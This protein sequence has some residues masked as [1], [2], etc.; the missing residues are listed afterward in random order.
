MSQNNLHRAHREWANRPADERFSNLSDL[1]SAV[2]NRYR[3]SLE[4]TIKMDQLLVEEVDGDDV[5]VKLKYP[6]TDVS[7]DVSHWSF[8]QLS[9]LSKAPAAYLRTLPANLVVAN[10][11]HSLRENRDDAKVLIETTVQGTAAAELSH[12]KAFTGVQYGRIWDIDVVRAVEALIAPNPS[13]KNPPAYR[14]GGKFGG[15]VVNSGLY[16][17]DR[18]VF[19]FFVDEDHRIFPKGV[20]GADDKGL[21]RGFFIWNSEVGKTSFG[22]TTFLYNYVCNNHIIWGASDV[23]EIRIRHSMNAPYRVAKEIMPQLQGYIESSAHG[24]EEAI[25]KA[26]DYKITTASTVEEQEADVAEFL[27]R[28]GFTRAAAREAFDFAVKEEGDGT[29]LW[30]VIQGVTAAAREKAHV[31]ARIDMERSAGKLMDFVK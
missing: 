7:L 13:W 30:N 20:R 17:S 19:M 11:N 25:Q 27:S 28:R 8:G 10:L 26:L 21:S 29:R 14:V 24:E 1:K 6:S 15:D 16:A 31:D 23:R 12:L 9:N 2:N 4:G 22:I 3:R 5:I 18:D